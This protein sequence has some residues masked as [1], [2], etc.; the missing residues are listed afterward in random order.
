MF[1]YLRIYKD[2]RT[3]PS[4]KKGFCISGGNELQRFIEKQ[5]QMK[6][7]EQA[8]HENHTHFKTDNAITDNP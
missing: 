1:L 8:Y 2:E 3:Y 5:N 6:C 7:V 4:K